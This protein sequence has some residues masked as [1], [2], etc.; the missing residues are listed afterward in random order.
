MPCKS[1]NDNR[2]Q[3]KICNEWNLPEE[4][5]TEHCCVYCIKEKRIDNET[6]SRFIKEDD[7]RGESKT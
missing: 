3:C 1:L 6:I 2:T 5:F 7:F 4:M